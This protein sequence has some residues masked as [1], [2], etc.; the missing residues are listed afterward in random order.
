M[1]QVAC[2]LIIDP[3]PNRGSWNMA[4][5]EALLEAAV[6]RSQCTLRWYRWDEAT[7]SLGYFQPA[8]ALAEFP[9]FASL[10]T[11]RRLSGGGA[12]LHHHELTYSCALPAGHELSREPH[13]L[14]ENIH[15][16]IIEVLSRHGI[17]ARLRGQDGQST[18]KPFLCFGRRDPNDV[19]IQG[20][21]ILGSAQR[22]RRGA[23]IQHGSLLLKIS[24]HAPEFPGIWDLAR[25]GRLENRLT[26]QL[27]CGISALLDDKVDQ[28]SLS[29]EDRRRA[30]ELEMRRYHTLDWRKRKRLDDIWMM[31][32]E[33][34]GDPEA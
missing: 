16:R 23:V 8:H 30:A 14:Y 20:H 29:T 31:A 34:N 6:E 4:V 3:Q 21:K 26:E 2:R 24:E 18:E 12:I 10:P 5:D 25:G 1:S 28:T 17:S 7:V 19:V 33:P 32:F 22:R 9:K 27:A 11:V 15:R 13:S